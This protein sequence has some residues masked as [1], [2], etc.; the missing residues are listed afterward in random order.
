[1]TCRVGGL[2]EWTK[3]EKM[4]GEYIYEPI[5]IYCLREPHQLEFKTKPCMPAS[6]APLDIRRIIS[7]LTGS[8]PL[9]SSM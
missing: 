7:I 8:Q 1:M 4:G 6:L 3:E 5:G 2:V 9:W